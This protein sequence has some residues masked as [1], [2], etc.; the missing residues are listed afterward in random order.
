MHR[1]HLALW[2]LL[3]SVLLSGCVA[4]CYPAEAVLQAVGSGSPFVVFRSDAEEYRIGERV[5]F[6]VQTL[7]SGYLTLTVADPSGQVSPLIRNLPV[8]AGRTQLIP[9]PGSRFEFIAG[10]PIGWHTVRAHFTPEPTSERVSLLGTF[11][12]AGWYAQI[13][14]ELEPYGFDRRFVTEARVL[15]R[16]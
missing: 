16:R 9:G 3:S 7:V 1:I 15:I 14:L 8:F 11:S 10:P 13:A 2:L 12:E 6:E 4:V 5:T